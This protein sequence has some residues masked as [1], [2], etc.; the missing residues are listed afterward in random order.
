[1]LLL[2]APLFSTVETTLNSLPPDLPVVVETSFFLANL[3]RI[4]ERVE[5]F[6]ANIYVDFKWND[7]RLIFTPGP[8]ESNLRIYT[9]DRAREKLKEIWWPQQD[10]LNDTYIQYNNLILTIQR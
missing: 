1:M 3:D 5:T 2:G 8:G 6:D 10:F 4:D 9:Q 7:P